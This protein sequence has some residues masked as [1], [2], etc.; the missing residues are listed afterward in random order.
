MSCNYVE[1][2]R[3]IYFPFP[4]YCISLPWNYLTQYLNLNISYMFPLSLLL[5]LPSKLSRNMITCV[6]M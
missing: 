4:R 1:T 5:K 3:Y 2:K 6:Q